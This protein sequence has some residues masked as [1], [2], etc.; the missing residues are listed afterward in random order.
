M[1]ILHLD[2]SLQD[3]LSTSR[4]ISREIVERLRETYADADIDYV[5]LVR[6]PLPHLSLDLLKAQDS[7]DVLKGFQDADL[8]VIGTA[9]YNFTLPSQLKAWIDRV[10]IAGETFRY[11]ANGPEGLCGGKRVIVALSRGGY[12]RENTPM[13]ALEHAETY[14]RSVFGFVGV[15]EVDVINIDGTAIPGNREP[16]LAQARQ[17]L[18][19]LAH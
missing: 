17:Q 9:M 14:L 19:E 13:A 12:Y 5:D 15:R 3:D 11:T 16:A 1:K 18:R 4:L 7:R 10:L 6:K 2:A 8:V